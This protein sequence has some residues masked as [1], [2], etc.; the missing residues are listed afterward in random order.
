MRPAA[1]LACASLIASLPV[2]AV[3]QSPATAE[4][5]VRSALARIEAIDRAGPRL[6][7]I[8]AVNSQALAEARAADARRRAGRSLGPLDGAVVVLKDNIEAAGPMATTAGSLALAENVTGRDAPVVARLRRAGVVILGKSNLSEWANYRSTRSVSG[9]SAAGG[10]TRNPFVLDRSACGSSSGSAVAVAA[11]IAAFAVGT[12][13]NGSITCPAATNGVV[14]LKPT[15]GLVSRTHIVPLSPAQDTAGPIARTVTDAALLL[16]AM[17]GSDPEDPATGEADTHK[18]DYAAG[19]RAD[20]LRGARIGVLRGATAGS[21]EG[22]AVFARALDT[23]RAAGAI[24]VEVRAPDAVQMAEMSGA[25][26]EALNSEFRAAIDAY[27]AD[28]APAVRA[29]SLRG[30]IDFNRTS[31]AEAG[32]FGQEIFEAALASPGLSDPVYLQR[33]A[34]AAR[35]AGPEGLDRM[36][37]EAGVEAIVAESG[38]P[39]AVID[40]VNGTRFLGSPSALPAIAGYPHLAVPMGDVSGLPVGLS[41]IG[42]KWA[43]GRILALGFAFEQA[44]RVRLEPKFLPT[45]SARSDLARAFDLPTSR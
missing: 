32:L 7:S 43:D 19:L 8:L 39:A 6:N 37:R 26:N 16:T 11:G 28:A 45:L 14:G 36:L 41:I 34:T 18:A 21:P 25:A 12:E 9:W 5:S 2:V 30:L 44:A 22:E 23:L 35:L 42:P 15:L 10:L 1:A 27:L 29:R 31:A 20:A 4:A 17:A 13:T 24:L 40:P 33:R 3:A 38:A